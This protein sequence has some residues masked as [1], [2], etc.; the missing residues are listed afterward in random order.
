[1]NPFGYYDNKSY[2]FSPMIGTRWISF[3]P[4]DVKKHMLTYTHLSCIQIKEKL[5]LL[6]L[7][8][9]LCESKKSRYRNE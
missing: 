7:S 9:L 2:P 3:D 4:T 5:F 6:S 1:M 8:K